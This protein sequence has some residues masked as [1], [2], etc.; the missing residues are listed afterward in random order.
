MVVALAAE[1]GGPESGCGLN[2]FPLP[3][4]N[5]NVCGIKDLW[6]SSAVQLLSTQI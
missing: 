2:F 5:T 3:A 1:A 6:C 4:G